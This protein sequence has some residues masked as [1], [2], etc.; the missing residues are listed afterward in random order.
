MKKLNILYIVLLLI[1]FSSCY[2][3]NGNYDYEIAEE[4]VIEGFGENYS[5]VMAVETLSIPITVKT[6]KNGELQY[7]WEV[8]L[9]VAPIFNPVRDTIATTKDLS[10]KL[11]KEPNWYILVLKIKNLATGYEKIVNTNLNITTQTTHGWFILKSKNEET[12]ID[13]Y[14]TK[15]KT[16][17]MP[18]PEMTVTNLLFN[19]N[20]RSLKGTG[21]QL[22]LFTSFGMQIGDQWVKYINTVM[23]TTDR[24]LMVAQT[25]SF[26]IE[27]TPENISYEQLS[28]IDPKFVLAAGMSYYMN[29]NGLLHSVDASGPNK[30][31]FGTS[32]RIDSNNTPYCLSKYIMTGYNLIFDELSTSLLKLDGYGGVTKLEDDPLTQMKSANTNKLCLF[33]GKRAPKYPYEGCGVFED[34]TTGERTIA[35][36]PDLAYMTKFKAIVTVVQKNEVANSASKFTLLRNESILYMLSADGDIWSRNLSNGVERRE[37]DVPS[38]E[39][40]TFIMNH[41]IDLTYSY[42]GHLFDCI[43]V[44]TTKGVG[45]NQ[46][47]TVKLYT[48]NAGSILTPDAPLMTFSGKG[49]AQDM[50]YIFDG[51]SSAW[52]IN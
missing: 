27:R 35:M 24:D 33:M 6:N 2:K 15:E 21:R 20:G 9:P 46:T 29:N 48:K 43:A 45:E 51:Y 16:G 30:G 44:A 19:V 39:T 4:I 7:T 17:F 3:D 40:V 52:S 41:F 37:L 26:R 14:A 11:I 1:S 8:F 13:F 50:I 42:P 28:T 22:E 12:D 5:V 38:D 47:Y 10:I 32:K 34:K 25:A 18:E 36:F 23:A 31:C 49:S